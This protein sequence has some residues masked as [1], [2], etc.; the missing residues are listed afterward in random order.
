MHVAEDIEQEFTPPNLFDSTEQVTK[1]FHTMAKENGLHPTFQVF[2]T[3][4]F[5]ES[6]SIPDKIWA[7]LEPLVKK[8]SILSG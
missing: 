3:K 1:F 4:T 7:E 5:R 6:L 2:K 8:R